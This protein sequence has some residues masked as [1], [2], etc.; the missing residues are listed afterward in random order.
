MET[1]TICAFNSFS[2]LVVEETASIRKLK[3]TVS[4]NL[5]LKIKRENGPQHISWYVTSNDTALSIKL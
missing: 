5:A 2:A 3:S 4:R 1:L